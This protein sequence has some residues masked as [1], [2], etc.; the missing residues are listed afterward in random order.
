MKPKTIY[1]NARNTE[2]VRR[3]FEMGGYVKEVVPRYELHKRFLSRLRFEAGINSASSNYGVGTWTRTY[4]GALQDRVHIECRVKHRRQGRART[5][6]FLSDYPESEATILAAMAAA[7]RGRGTLD[8]IAN[9][10]TWES[11]GH[12]SAALEHAELEINRHLASE[13]F[14]W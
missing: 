13:E 12:R 7:D 14:R 8:A 3:G 6:W 5:T 2:A 9:D 11:D 4:Y 1:A 10:K